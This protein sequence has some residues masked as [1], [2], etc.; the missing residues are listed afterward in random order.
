M[1]LIVGLGNPGAKYRLNRHNVG[2][3]FLDYLQEK[4][5][6][7]G[8]KL[9]K[10]VEA[11]TCKIK[12]NSQEIILVKPQT[13]MNRS[14]AAVKKNV[15]SFRLHVSD[16]YVVH[17]DLDIRLGEFKIQKGKGPQLHNGIESIEQNLQT[18]DFW[19]VRIGVDNRD[20]N[21]RTN[22][23][24][25]ILED[26]NREELIILDR[27]FAQIHEELQSLIAVPTR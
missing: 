7:G 16:L 14:G 1:K 2:W 24:R 12:I 21:D 5:E 13:F 25:Y 17:D 26:F 19:R 15:S 3:L 10:K 27:V 4:V 11:E 23:E 8:W 6:D 18:K 20:V 22:G 9:E